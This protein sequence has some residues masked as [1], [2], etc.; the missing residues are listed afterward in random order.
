MATEQL[1]DTVTPPTAPELGE[2]DGDE[3]L[4][5]KNVPSAQHPA[6]PLPSTRMEPLH[7]SNR[8]TDAYL[9]RTVACS[10]ITHRPCRML[11]QSHNGPC[12]LIAIAN[13]LLLNGT[14]RLTSANVSSGECIEADEL[15]V[16][17][18][19]TL[20]GVYYDE[21]ERMMQ[22]TGGWDGSLVEHVGK[23]LDGMQDGL[24]VNPHFD[25]IFHFGPTAGTMAKE[26]ESGSSSPTSNN[27]S[28]RSE[29]AI[30]KRSALN[31]FPELLLFELA[32]T[33]LCH[34]MIVGE[35]MR[36]AVGDAHYDE[37]VN[38]SYDSAMDAICAEDKLEDNPSTPSS[39]THKP[40]FFICIAAI[41]KMFI[42]DNADLM[43]PTGLVALKTRLPHG[44]LH[45]LFH[46]AHYSVVINTPSGLFRLVTDAGHHSYHD[47]A[48]GNTAK[49]PAGDGPVWESVEQLDG[50]THYYDAYFHSM[51]STADKPP[52]NNAPNECS[53]RRRKQK[54]PF[55]CTIQ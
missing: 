41:M 25:D 52:L 23:T 28:S 49:A 32:K 47:A 5:K 13:V 16:V 27:D 40:T 44:V 43:T 10:P 53:H 11:V 35:E 17:L 50:N 54:A 51:P 9:L 22:L 3:P 1:I 20:V 39:G 30:D 55:R 12:A 14:L 18:G 26:E 31:I 45:I 24:C 38:A 6:P 36:R 4:T 8:R 21:P 37:L 46:N 34:G 48:Q 2:G 29:D 19:S 15:L 7:P 33:Q 42:D